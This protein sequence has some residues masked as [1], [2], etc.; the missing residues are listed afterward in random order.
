MDILADLNPPQRQAVEAV[1]GPLLILAGPGS[2]KTRVITHRIAHLTTIWDIK[3]HRIMAVTFT[4]KAA[5]EMK[6]RLSVL[7]GERAKSLTV[8]TFHAICASIL[9]RD[10]AAAGIDPKYVIYDDADQLALM[11]RCMQE[12]CIDPKTHPPKPLLSAISRAKSQLLSPGDCSL[13][14]ESYFEEVLHRV[15]THYQDLLSAN[16]ALDFD[17][18]LMMTHH[19]FDKHPDVLS[20]YQSRYLHVLVD[21]FQDTNITQYAL[22]RQFAGKHRNICVVGDPD[23]SI[24][25][26]RHA[27]IRNILNFGKDYSEAKTVYLEQNYRSTKGILAAAHG[28]IA[29]NRDR[30]DHGLW[31]E[32]EEGSPITIV[33]APSETSEAQF[34]VGEIQRLMASGEARARDCA[35][36]Y[37]TNAQ[38]R[39]VEECFV[40]YGI[41]YQLVG[42]IRFYERREVKDMIAYLRVL[43]NPFD[44]ISLLRIIN[45]PARNIGQ[46]TVERLSQLAQSQG[47]PVFV[48]LQRLLQSSEV[49][50]GL[51]S[52]A[53]RALEAFWELITQLIAESQ[54]MDLVDLLD[55][56]INKT[57]YQTYLDNLEDGGERWE[58]LLEL[59]GLANEYAALGPAE[60]LA[61]FLEGVMLFS[62]TDELDEKRDV[63]TLITLHQAKGLEF[64]VV[65]IL[66]VEEGVLPHSRSLNDRSQMEEERRICYVGMTRAKKRL[67]LVRATER[68]LLGEMKSNPPSR[69]LRDIPGNLCQEIDLNWSMDTCAPPETKQRQAEYDAGDYVRHAKFGDGVIV[70]CAPTRDDQ[71]LLIAFEKVGM[72]K[73]LASVAPLERMSSPELLDD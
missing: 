41:P 36:M 35:I 11:K 32:N 42:S 10:G 26:W 4:N 16:H 3:P 17:D 63:A 14:I 20:K 67:Y 58:N 62:D 52:R 38:S 19:L 15:Y 5:R 60:G 68:R 65:F 27:D 70:S 57:G 55:A 69:Y 71:E 46:K 48:A 51:T 24:Y 44:G 22:L 31:T 40:R 25:S 45:T 50:A 7:M 33:K 13:R 47:V 12:L 21:E 61:A 64:P 1:E 9:R 30:I 66:G 43:H 18:L 2:G 59:R 34:V 39:V 23:Q 8:G 6:E 49:P 72:K 54:E 37:R 29:V 53:V 28:V 73:L 56:V